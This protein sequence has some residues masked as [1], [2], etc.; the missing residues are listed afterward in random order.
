MEKG[1]L[2]SFI[3]AIMVTTVLSY[4]KY[5]PVCPIQLGT[6]VTGNFSFI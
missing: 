3:I 1:Y 4:N 5:G 2:S 6:I